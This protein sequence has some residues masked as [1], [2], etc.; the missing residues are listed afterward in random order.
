MN[1][2]FPLNF[3]TS[4]VVCDG[5]LMLSGLVLMALALVAIAAGSVGSTARSDVK[6]SPTPVQVQ[7]DEESETASL[8]CVELTQMRLSDW[9]DR[10]LRR[11]ERAL[12]R[13]AVV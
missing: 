3:P 7:M 8:E 10:A 13:K 11:E 2:H 1:R 4:G 5:L 12:R 6:K 9:L